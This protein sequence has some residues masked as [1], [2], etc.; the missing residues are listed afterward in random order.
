MKLFSFL[1]DDQQLSVGVETAD[2][3]LNLTQ[4]F[5]IY[6][7]AKRVKQPVSFAFLQVMIEMGYTSAQAIEKILS[8]SWV[9]SKI[10]RIR[11]PETLQIDVPVARPSKIVA[12]GRNYADHAKELNHEIP[13]ELC[14]FCKAPSSII[15]H[16][17]DIIIPDWYDG[18]VHHEAEL[19]IIMGKA[20]R[21]VP[22]ED[23][24]MYVAGFSILN[25]VTARSMQKEDI[26]K[27]NPWFRSKS[28]DSFCPIGPYFVPVDA[29]DDPHNLNIRLTVNGKERQNSNTSLM[30]FRIEEII[31]EV[32][33]FMTLLPGD[34]IA[35]G[36][37]KG[38]GPIVHGDEIEVTIDGLGT[39]RNRVVKV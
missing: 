31:A 5:D 29:M 19:T 30:L 17:D 22:V 34:I 16:E 20:A 36:T 24:M 10:D 23:A 9:Q 27:G 3:K 8:D 38:V 25:D 32:S 33:K 15:A 39:L 12:I 1:T 13:D 4:A 6:Q 14:F 2:E 37:P 18:D 35:T 21:N 28:F 26:G 7:H 11:L